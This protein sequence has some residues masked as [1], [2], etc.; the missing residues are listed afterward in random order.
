M[1]AAS[2]APSTL[3]APHAA[4]GIVPRSFVG[5]SIS[6]LESTVPTTTI[7]TWNT[8]A[9]SLCDADGFPHTEKDALDWSKRALLMESE[10]FPTTR[11]H[12]S[13]IALQEMD[14]DVAEE[15]LRPLCE[16]YRMQLLYAKKASADNRDGCALLVDTA[17]WKVVTSQR[18]ILGPSPG[19]SQV[20]LVAHLQQIPPPTPS[21]MIGHTP[22]QLLV[23][24]VHLKS[25]PGHEEVRLGQI[26]GLLNVMELLYPDH[27]ET[28]HTL[29][30]GDFND[31]PSSLACTTMR[32]AGFTS[33]YDADDAPYTTAKKRQ[34]VV[35]RTID[36]MWWRAPIATATPISFK[37]L[38]AIP[39][40]TAFPTWLPS[41]HYPSDHMALAA[42]LVL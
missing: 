19:T 3:A 37:R 42:Q 30:L 11:P 36:Y 23:A 32:E 27:R 41:T 34:A 8:L 40:I 5:S 4:Q 13:I 7:M 33:L 38:L 25:K 26:A 14:E 31:I 35:Q 28:H 1:A 15:W 22:V 12:A 16:K 29:V 18:V 10:L 24:S 17:K 9:R 20:A 2:V 6:T 21:T 39:P